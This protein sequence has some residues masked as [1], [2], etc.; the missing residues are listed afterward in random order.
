LLP[1]GYTTEGQN[2]KLNRY[3]ADAAAVGSTLVPFVVE[4]FGGIG[5]RAD[6]LMKSLAGLAAASGAP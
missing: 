6:R 3:D 5:D 4:S 2:R 1:L